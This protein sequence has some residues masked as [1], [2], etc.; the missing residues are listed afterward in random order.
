MGDTGPLRV[1]LTFDAEHP[2]RPR[3]PPGNVERILDTLRNESAR[4]TFFVQGR[5]AEAYPDLARRIAEDGH[6]VGHHSKYHARM[7]LLHDEGVRED[8]REGAEAIIAAT[9]VDPRPWFRCPFGDGHDDPRVLAAL[10][11]AGYRNHHWD[12]EPDDW[13]PERTPIDLERL[14]VEG[15]LDHGDGAVI[16]LHSWPPATIAALPAIVDGLRGRGASL[17]GLDEAAA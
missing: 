2:D 1:A 15:A 5:W 9:G 16:L 4:A 17:V 7:P 11:R 12:V 13:R 6:L 3:C 8:L 10:E 14:V